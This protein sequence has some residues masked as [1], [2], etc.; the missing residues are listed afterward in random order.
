[1]HAEMSAS[2]RVATELAG[3]GWNETASALGKGP[4]AVCA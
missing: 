4:E 2:E 1:M 3:H